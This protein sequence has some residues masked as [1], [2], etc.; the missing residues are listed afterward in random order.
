[1]EIKI[2]ATAGIIIWYIFRLCL[3]I[4]AISEMRKQKH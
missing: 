2:L 1:M 4:L 3:D